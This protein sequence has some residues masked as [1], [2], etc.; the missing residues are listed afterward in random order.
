MSVEKNKDIVKKWDNTLF[1]CDENNIIIT[2][3]ELF[4]PEFTIFNERHTSESYGKAF[5]K[6][7][8]NNWNP[9]DTKR[10]KITYI[11]EG[12]SVVSVHELPFEYKNRTWDGLRI[13]YHKIKKGKIVDI[14]PVNNFQD[15]RKQVDNGE[16][17]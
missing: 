3:K 2:A 13:V 7:M 9:E 12:D 15:I 11:G 14:K 16:I 17:I 1:G 6:I 4:A 5:A 10:L 8:G